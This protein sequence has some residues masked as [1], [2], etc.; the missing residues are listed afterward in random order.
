MQI[1]WFWPWHSKAHQKIS[2][3]PNAE[4]WPLSGIYV[5]TVFEFQ[6]NAAQSASAYYSSFLYIPASLP[7]EWNI[8]RD[9]HTLAQAPDA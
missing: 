4:P 3:T 1:V 5:L 6:H 2:N 7:R 9:A 8:F